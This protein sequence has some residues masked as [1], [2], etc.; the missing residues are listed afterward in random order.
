M[1]TVFL[2]A[3][4]APPA[5]SAPSAAPSEAQAA[6]VAEAPPAATG[7]ALAL[8]GTITYDGPVTG[9]AVFV[10]VKDPAHPGPPLA[11]KK[12][13][14]GPFPL[15]FTLTDADRMQMG[16]G[17]ALP[18]SVNLVVRLD[19]DGDAMTKVPTEPVATVETAASNAAVAV[20]LAVK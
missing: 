1:F 6:P 10:S 11:A 5:P 7:A 16:G 17:G 12:L 3:C 2:A 19:G 13:P 4:G 20:T 8:S 9:A 14:P 15:A 18:A